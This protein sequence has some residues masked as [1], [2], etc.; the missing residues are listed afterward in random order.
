[1]WVGYVRLPVSVA[2]AESARWAGRD[3]EEGSGGSP[4]A[5]EVLLLQEALLQ[6]AGLTVAANPVLDSSFSG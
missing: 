2:L 3:G 6:P 4:R 5:P 1:V